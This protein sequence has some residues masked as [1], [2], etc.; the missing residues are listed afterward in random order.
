[1]ARF[2]SPTVIFID[3]VDALCSK[4][5]DNDCDASRRVKSE[6]LTQMEPSFLYFENIFGEFF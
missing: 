1:M 5:G 3:E 4:R 6:F 2:Y